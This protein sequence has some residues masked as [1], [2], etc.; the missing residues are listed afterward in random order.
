MG[1]ME[2]SSTLRMATNVDFMGKTGIF[3]FISGVTKT[4]Q[5]I[6]GIRHWTC[7]IRKIKF[8]YNMEM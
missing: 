6:Q 7:I 1:E 3:K 5:E 8:H 4:P 2:G